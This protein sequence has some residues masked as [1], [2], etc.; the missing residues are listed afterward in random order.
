MKLSYVSFTAAL[1]VASTSASASEM[2]NINF[3]IIQPDDHYFFQEWDPPSTLSGKNSQQPKYPYENYLPN[4]EN[5]IRN[6][7]VSL[8][9]KNSYASAAMCGTSRYSTITGRYPSRSSLGRMLD[10]RS[11]L[12]DVKIP[13]TKLEDVSGVDDPK[14][15]SD[16]NIAALLQQNGVSNPKYINELWC[17]YYHD[18]TLSHIL[19][20][21]YHRFFCFV[22]LVTYP[23]YRTG[24]FGKW[25]LSDNDDV[26]YDRI[27]RMVKDCGFDTAEAIY[28][29]NMVG[30]WYGDAT[31]NMEHL[32]A[33]ALEFIR[34]NQDE[35]FFLYFNPTVPHDTQDVTDALRY[36]DCRDRIDGRRR[37]PKVF[38]GEMS[39]YNNGSDDDDDCSKY[40]RS[41]LDR[42]DSNDDKMAGA[43]WIDD[44][45]GSIM[46]AL[47]A[48]DILD[49]TFILFQLDHGVSAKGR[50]VHPIRQFL[51]ISM[52]QC[53][54]QYYTNSSFRIDRSSRTNSSI[55]LLL[56][57]FF[58]FSLIMI[59]DNMTAYLRVSFFF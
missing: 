49:Q 52:A 47:E 4:I 44:S 39:K 12:R 7:P 34:D 23:Q 48:Y 19:F 30:R 16:N 25:H 41:V 59:V 58:L 29:E 14:D 13:Y 56:R 35:P 18:V 33:E 11:S 15:C 2:K 54:V 55:I 50:Y 24:V 38:F 37:T 45:V 9:M 20:I 40:R 27:Q 21:L 22:I 42:A 28:K 31:H 36:G 57:F 6:A 5:R 51:H 26:S 3:I 8:D 53:S 32:T 10:R 46:D 1:L 43:V 17:R